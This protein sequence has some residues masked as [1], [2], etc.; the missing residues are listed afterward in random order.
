MNR[1]SALAVAVSLLAAGCSKNTPTAPSATQP[2]FTAALSGN[3]EN[4]PIANA[5]A[6]GTG[7]ATITFNTTVAGG[8]ITAATADFAVSIAGLPANTP[9][10]LSHIHEGAAGVNGGVRVDL[11]LAGDNIVLANG[12]G[13]F[14]K[15]N[16]SMTPELAQAIMNNPA[17]YYFNSHS[18]INGGGVV[19]GQLVRTQ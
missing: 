19:R 4:P 18:V 8:Q 14:T 2:K 17:G 10:R 9:I 3:N 15:N 13:S 5:E 7:T 12:S 1:W 11:A 16:I 6:G